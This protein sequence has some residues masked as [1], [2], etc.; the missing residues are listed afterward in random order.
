MLKY[1]LQLGLRRLRRNPVLT[2]LMVM[3]IG[4]GV[5]S[6]MTTYTVLRAM[7]GDPIPWKSDKL[8]FPQIDAWG[9]DSRRNGTEPR[10]AMTYVDAVSMMRDHRAHLQ[11]ALYPIAPT[12]HSD[13]ATQK[14]RTAPGQAVYSEFFPMLDVPFLYGGGWTAADDEQ[15]AKVAVITKSLNQR[16]FKG[17]NSVGRS[18]Q[19]DSHSY[20]VS[21]VLDDW[22]PQPK[23]YDLATTDAFGPADQVFLPFTT[24]TDAQLATKSGF[25]CVQL[26]DPGYAAMLSSSCVWIGYMVE[27]GSP[28]EVSAYR[29]YLDGYA[30]DQQASGRF[31]WAPNNRLSDLPAWLDFWQVVPSQTKIS[32]VV[33]L[34][35]LLVCMVNT[36]GLLL[37][38]FLR[39]S[40]EIGVR[41]ALGASR[42]AIAAQ[43]GVEAGTIGAA[44]GLFGLMLTWAGIQAM[45]GLLPRQIA[46]L[47]HIDPL[48]LWQ[49][50]LLAVVATVLAG[51]YPIWRAMYVRP[52][53]QLKED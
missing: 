33:A 46:A 11:T 10:A 6:S 15:H 2:A 41:R 19:L 20:R 51:L 14:S 27:L 37:A 45:H 3:A 23:F 5:A 1:Y 18:I 38:K 32:F 28:S 29:A 50:L 21:G 43:F 36:V 12:V 31:G 52:S 48:L 53:L 17:E 7:S 25:M 40:G 13:D 44:G 8:F 35:L 4:F 9:P 22:H 42:L 26:P 47:A 30:H 49:T 24:A 39:R 16:L 34:C